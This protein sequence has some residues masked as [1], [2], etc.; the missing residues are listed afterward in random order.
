MLLGCH[1]LWSTTAN[2]VGTEEQKARIEKLII[3]NNY[4][5]GGL[6]D[7]G[8]TRFNT[9]CIRSCQTPKQ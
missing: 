6:S 7:A 3:E 2:I 4:F 8:S 5:V 1:L 9:D